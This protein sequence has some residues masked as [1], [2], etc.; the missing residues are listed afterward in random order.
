ME[1]CASVIIW[2]PESTPCV[3]FNFYHESFGQAVATVGHR[4]STARHSADD[5]KF[6]KA[7]ASIKQF[8]GS[9]SMIGN[10]AESYVTLRTETADQ[11]HDLEQMLGALK[12]LSSFS[13]SQQRSNK[14]ARGLPDIL[15]DLSITT[16][17]NEVEIRL[18]LSQADMQ[19]LIRQF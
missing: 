14:E 5:E 8:Y 9:V 7:I 15:K 4:G 2:Q 3:L 11:A 10:D 1:W 13:V 6:T 12:L 16:Q 18:K 19:S 17:S